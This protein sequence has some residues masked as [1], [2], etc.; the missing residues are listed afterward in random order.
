VEQRQYEPAYRR[1]D[2]EPAMSNVQMLRE[3]DERLKDHDKLINE[4]TGALKLL[5]ILAGIGAGGTIVTLI[6]LMAKGR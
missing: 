6:D 1:W 5:K 4:I 3:H 2:D